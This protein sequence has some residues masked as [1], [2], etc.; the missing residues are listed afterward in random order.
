LWYRE[1]ERVRDWVERAKVAERRVA[2]LQWQLDSYV[3]RVLALPRPPVPEELRVV[4]PSLPKSVAEF[5]AGL[6]DPDARAEYEALWRQAVAADPNLSPK[7]WVEAQ[8]ARVVR[9]A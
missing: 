4:E 1:L 3:A 9:D 5:L 7:D 8:L 6:D 2:V